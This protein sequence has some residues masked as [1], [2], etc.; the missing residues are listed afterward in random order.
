MPS[1]NG[2]PLSVRLL[3]TRSRADPGAAKALPCLG[4]GACVLVNVF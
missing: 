1:D 4:E 2:Q 3:G